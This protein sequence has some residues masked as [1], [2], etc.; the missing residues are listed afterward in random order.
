MHPGP[1]QVTMSTSLLDSSPPRL[2]EQR[3]H[4]KVDES[5]NQPSTAEGEQFLKQPV[6][7]ERPNAVPKNNTRQKVEAN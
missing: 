7:C 3:R 5:Q 4:T 1:I 2:E 6:F